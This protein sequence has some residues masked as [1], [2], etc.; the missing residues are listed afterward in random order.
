MRDDYWIRYHEKAG[1]PASRYVHEISRHGNRVEISGVVA[2]IWIGRE[3][4]SPD[5]WHIE[6]SPGEKPGRAPWQRS[7]A[8]HCLVARFATDTEAW[9]SVRATIVEIGLANLRAGLLHP[10]G[11]QSI[12]KPWHRVNLL[13]RSLFRR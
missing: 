4:G 9:E 13:W 10:S 6:I 5:R 11:G 7:P 1:V 8:T 12:D 3:A 2:W